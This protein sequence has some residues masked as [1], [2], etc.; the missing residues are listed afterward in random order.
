MDAVCYSEHLYEAAWLMSYTEKEKDKEWLR[1][2]TERRRKE[3]SDRAKELNIARHK[4]TYKAKELVIE[5]WKRLEP[6]GISPPR[7]GN[8][9]SKWLESQSLSYEPTTITNWIRAYKKEIAAK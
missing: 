7:A 2:D 3:K 5:E 8:K 4:E 1:I 9:L 6:T